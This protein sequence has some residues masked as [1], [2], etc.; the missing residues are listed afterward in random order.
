MSLKN[1]AHLGKEFIIIF[2]NRLYFNTRA[3]NFSDLFF[4]KKNRPIKNINFN[5]FK[6]I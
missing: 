4:D 1:N 5:H 6:N 3:H 2:K